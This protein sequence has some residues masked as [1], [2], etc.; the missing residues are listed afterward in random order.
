MSVTLPETGRFQFGNVV[1]RTFNTIGANL[2]VFLGLGILLSFLPDAALALMRNALGW[3]SP[4]A[5][6][7]TNLPSNL[8]GIILTGAVISG[9]LASFA[10]RPVSFAGCLN[11]GLRNFGGLFVVGLLTG[12][13]VI[14]GLILLIVP[15][16]IWLTAWS[17][18]G[19]AWVAERGGYTAAI[20]RSLRLTRGHRWPIFGLIV[21]TFL[22]LLII[23]MV[24]GALSVVIHP[25]L[26]QAWSPDA[27]DEVVISPLLVMAFMIIVATGG[28]AI[29]YELP[30][31]KAGA[32]A[33]S[34]AATFD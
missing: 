14:G 9:S 23:A 10:G 21:I 30:G 2:G 20:G 31:T 6:N 33:E 7:L 18:A 28:A 15:G 5:Q 11:D 1:S 8:V 22:M 19:P 27:L 32:A 24:F 17:V 13:G 25:L 12:L 3:T 26:P 16:L 34:V 4:A 29:Y